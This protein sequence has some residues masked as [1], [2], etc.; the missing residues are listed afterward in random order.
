LVFGKFR[1]KA[2]DVNVWRLFRIRGRMRSRGL[3]NLLHAERLF[4]LARGREVRGFRIDGRE[5][6]SWTRRGTGRSRRTRLRRKDR[7]ID[8]KDRVIVNNLT[9][10]KF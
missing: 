4:A 2:V 3:D 7:G 9:G 10:F 8:Y 6:D 5:R 1:G